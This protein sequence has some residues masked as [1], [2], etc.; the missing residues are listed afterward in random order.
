MAFTFMLNFIP[1]YPKKLSWKHNNCSQSVSGVPEALHF[2][3][4]VVSNT[5]TSRGIWI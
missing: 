5:M 2:H 1:V 4:A 3:A